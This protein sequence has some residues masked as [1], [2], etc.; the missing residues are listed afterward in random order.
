MVVPVDEQVQGSEQKLTLRDLRKRK[1]LNLA[2]LG[3]IMGRTHAR[4]SQIENHGT[5]KM[6]VLKRLAEIYEVDFEVVKEA[7]D[8]L[9][10]Q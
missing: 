6:S 4:M 3:R 2:E 5:D 10:S 7:N 1:G 8:S 9:P